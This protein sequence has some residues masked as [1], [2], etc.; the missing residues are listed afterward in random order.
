MLPARMRLAPRCAALA[1]MQPA[2]RPA[3]NG[4][5][6]AG[7]TG[8]LRTGAAARRPGRIAAPVAVPQGFPKGQ[9][10]RAATARGGSNRRPRR[11][12]G[13][14]FRPGDLQPGRGLGAHDPGLG[15]HHRENLVD[16]GK[17]RVG[18]A[19]SRPR[20]PLQAAKRLAELG[21]NPAGA[22][23]VL[24]KIGRV[25]ANRYSHSGFYCNRILP[26]LG[27][28][29]ILSQQ[30]GRRRPRRPIMTARPSPSAAS[31]S[32]SGTAAGVSPCG[33]R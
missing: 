23:H 18:I 33:F 4:G 7:E 8:P 3:A 9:R 5:L 31:E 29:P 15:L 22:E 19:R 32:G 28:L 30:M 12:R 2:G 16:G 24:K 20:L 17:Q 21:R 13:A 14:R 6:A 27:C 10:V 1:A 25:H 26:G 11:H